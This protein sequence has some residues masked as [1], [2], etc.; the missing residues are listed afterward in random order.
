MNEA[1]RKNRI[2]AGAIKSGELAKQRGL[3]VREKYRSS[4]KHCPGCGIVLSY[5]KRYNTFCSRSCATTSHNFGRQKRAEITWICALCGNDVSSTSRK[6]P[7]KYCNKESALN[8]VRI[9][10]YLKW[11]NLKKLPSPKRIRWIYK[12]FGLYECSMCEISSWNGSELILQT[13]HID[14]NPENNSIDNIRLICP[15]CH[16]Q[17]DT[18]GSRN[19]GNGRE[20][21][22]V[23]RAKYPERAW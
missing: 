14:G 8:N 17:T 20:S 13:D 2:V 22:R 7:G 23:S 4:P 18:F 1:E 21:R 10:S 6:N 11:I 5:E 15:N 3:A 12:Q 16:S 19:R 9:N